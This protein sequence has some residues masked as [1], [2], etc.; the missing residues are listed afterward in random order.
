MKRAIANNGRSVRSGYADF[1]R[2]NAA[3]PERDEDKPTTVV[4]GCGVCACADVLPE[5]DLVLAGINLVADTRDALP[6][7][8]GAIRIDDSPE[9]LQ[10]RRSRRIGIVGQ[11]AHHHTRRRQ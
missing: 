8:G 5:L 4:K 7:S 2:S 1:S 10:L 6:A 9:C 11:G 3:V